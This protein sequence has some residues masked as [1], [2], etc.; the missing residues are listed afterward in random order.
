MIEIY[1]WLICV[2][3]VTQI[4]T[5]FENLKG[6]S[7]RGEVGHI[8]RYERHLDV[9]MCEKKLTEAVRCSHSKNLAKSSI[10][11]KRLVM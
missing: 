5:A 11:T 1:Y 10:P 9:S 8:R 7:H 3:V 6:A 2:K 4:H